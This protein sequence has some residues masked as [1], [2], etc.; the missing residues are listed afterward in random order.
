[1]NWSEY[2]IKSKSCF[3]VRLSKN[4]LFRRNIE[5]SGADVCQNAVYQN[6]NK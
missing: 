6:I 3:P 4:A 5:L 1:M 2:E